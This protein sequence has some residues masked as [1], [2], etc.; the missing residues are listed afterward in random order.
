MPRPCKQ[1]RICALPG[2]R[3]F[4][5]REP[6]SDAGSLVMTLD[7]YEAL[8]LIDLEAL[9]QEECAGRMGVARTTAQAIYNSARRKLANCLVHGRELRIEGGHY[10]LCGGGLPG[11]RASR[12]PHPGTFAP[13]AHT[14]PTE[15][16][17]TMKIA[18]TYE[19]GEIFQHFGHT[20]QFKLYTVENGQ[21]TGSR[22]VDTLGSGHGALAGF[23]QGLGVD[24]LLC[25]GI[26]GGARQ[27]LAQAGIQVYGGVQGR[28]DMA[29]SDF[30]AGRLIFNP[31]ELCDHH[32]E[33]HGEGHHCGEHGCGEHSC[34][35]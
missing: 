14:P 16:K 1:R 15:R 24:T 6:A 35:G 13:P 22:V 11:C 25:G 18:V 12:C 23:L 9:S 28:A 20:Q 27:A 2:C 7:E 26:G 17:Q 29:V 31:D 32:G 3:R 5:P 33:G 8:R 34:Q 30:L 21:I 4:G 10:C 19:N